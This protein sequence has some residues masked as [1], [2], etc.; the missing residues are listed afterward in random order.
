MPSH[1]T[2]IMGGLNVRIKQLSGWFC[3]S[4][5]KIIWTQRQNDFKINFLLS[6][7]TKNDFPEIL[8]ISL[9]GIKFRMSSTCLFS[10]E[11]DLN[12]GILSDSI[13][14]F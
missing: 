6:Y 8:P 12:E 7:R 11:I 10:A 5:W 1:K 9:L 13:T 2:L 3:F 4:I 14:G